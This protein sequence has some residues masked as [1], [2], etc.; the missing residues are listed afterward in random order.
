MKPTSYLVLGAFVLACLGGIL[1]A[2]IALGPLAFGPR[3]ERVAYFGADARVEPGVQI[4]TAGTQVGQVDKVELVPDDEIAPGH[5][6][7]VEISLIEGLTLWRG[8]EMVIVP[9]SALG[10]QLLQ[11]HRG[12]PGGDVIPLD[13]PLHGRTQ[14]GLMESLTRISEEIETG[15][16]L[17][18]RI[19]Y[20]TKLSDQIENAVNNLDTIIEEAA[21]GKGT[22]GMLLKDD[23]PMKSLKAA[24]ATLNESLDE[25]KEKGTV[26]KVDAAVEDIQVSLHWLREKV[27]GLDNK[28]GVLSVLLDEQAVDE[29]NATIY[30]LRKTSTELNSWLN[31]GDGTIPQLL[32]EKDVYEKLLVVSANLESAS[33]D[34]SALTAQVNRGEGTLGRIIRDDAL[35]DEAKRML[36]AFREGGEISRE[37]AP[38]ATVVT[39]SAFLF[40]VLN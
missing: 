38:L 22:I 34:L 4:L 5:Y 12:D 26:G 29:L 37:N 17:I 35:Y 32:R 30:S 3:D 28:A 8:A 21:T 14:G 25:L 27:E 19:V 1:W 13:E 24:L 7:R 33:S 20:D 15:S 23:T 10:G 31:S 11:L 9:R 2:A 18:H 36:E 39:F 40:S 16:G 6:V